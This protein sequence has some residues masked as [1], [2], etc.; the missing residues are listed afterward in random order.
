[1]KKL[2]GFILGLVLYTT[3]NA[4][5][6]MSKVE[7][8]K[9]DREAIT[10]EIPFPE[11]MIVK[12]IEDTLEK[13][14]Y[15]GKESK[16]FTVYKGVKLSALGSEA[17][18]LYFTVD[19]K[20]K[21]EKDISQ[22]TLMISK[23]FDSF[24]TEKSD[25]GLVKNAKN[26]LDSLRNTIAVYDLEQ[27]IAGQEEVVKKNEKKA[28]GLIEDADDLQK[29]KKKLE[30]EIENNIKEQADQQKEL[31]KQKQILSTLKRTGNQ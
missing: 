10:N 23:G 3:A 17:Y 16:G 4:Q 15:K 18:D 1:M 11:D 19:R 9:T 6:R 30:K 13:L 7:Y 29:K 28:S 21:K 31:E 12:A 5:S 27:Q 20:S 8:Q 22:V 26:Y 24:V 25:P 14:G 2:I